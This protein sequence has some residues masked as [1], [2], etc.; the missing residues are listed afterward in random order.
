MQTIHSICLFSMAFQYPP[1]PPI[2]SAIRTFHAIE[3]AFFESYN[4]RAQVRYAIRLPQ[5][6]PIVCG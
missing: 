6:M 3:L 5:M 4:T 1:T 2:T